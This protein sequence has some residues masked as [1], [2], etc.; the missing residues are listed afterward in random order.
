MYCIFQNS[1]PIEGM[2]NILTVLLIFIFASQLSGQKSKDLKSSFG[3]SIFNTGYS[4]D[5]SI[6]K[7]LTER[8][9]EA[10]L[11]LK[12]KERQ[13]SRL[14]SNAPLRTIPVVFHLLESTPTYTDDDVK[15]A[16]ASLNN[17][18]SH[19]NNNPNGQ[20]FSQGNIGVDTRIEFC[21]AQRAPDGGLTNG[22][23]RWTT[24]YENFDQDLED[25]KL[26][27]QGQWDPRYYLNIWIVARIDAELNA[28]YTG[29]TW[30]TRTRPA[31]YSGGP[32]GI[33][34]VDARVDGVIAA[35]MGPGLLAH[36]IGHYMSL[37][38]TF[39]ESCANGNC[40]VDG[41]QVCDTPP[42]VI[43]NSGECNRAD[44]S[45][46]TDTLSNYSN[47]N[48]P[49]D[50]PDMVTNFMDYSSCPHDFTQ[51]QAD[52]MLFT[53]DNY[54]IN[55]AVEAPS[56][57]DACIRPC[58]EDINISFDISER[59]PEPN[60]AID[61]TSTGLA[62]DT[63]E[64]YID[65]LG[66]P[67]SD[68]TITWEK[69]Y[70]PANPL[71]G[72]AA[73]LQFTFTDPGKYR[74]YL[75]AWNSATPDCYTSYSRVVRVTCG[76]IDARFFPDKRIIASKLTRA[77]LL[78]SVLFKNRSVNADSFEWIVEHEPYD[79][80]LPAQPEFRSDSTDL[81]Y[82]FTE[83]GD[84]RITLIASQGACVDT[85]GPFTL[86][87]LD[88]T[89]DASLQII[90][91]DCYK[92]DSLRVA[93]RV[94]NDGFDTIRIGM[95]VTFYDKNPLSPGPGPQI[96]KTIKLDRLV[97]GK[98]L[99]EDFVVIIPG[100][101]AKLDQLWA[102]INDPG[103]NVFPIT[104][105][106]N[107]RNVMS[108]NSV[109]PPSG[110][111]ELSYANNNTGTTSFQF[112]GV[113]SIDGPLKCTDQEVQLAASFIN[114]STLNSIS[115][116]ANNNL[117]CTNCFDPIAKLVDNQTSM[118]S[119]IFTSEYFCKDTVSITLPEAGEVVPLPTVNPV[120]ALCKGEQSLN[121]ANFANG[122]NLK[123]YPD[124]NSTNGNTSPPS[125]N[126]N[127]PG[128]YTLWLSQT[129][130]SC[131]GE[132]VPINYTINDAPD[133]PTINLQ[134]SI[135]VGGTLPDWGTWVSGNN[136]I[137][138]DNPNSGTPSNTPPNLNTTAAGNF[139]I[140]VSQSNGQ[141]ESPRVEAIYSI[142][143][144]PGAPSISGSP[145][146]CPGENATNLGSEVSGSNLL[147]YNSSNG[148]SGMDSLPMI[149]TTNPGTISFW[150]SQS[151]GQCES[152][153]ARY[154]IEILSPSPPPQVSTIPDVCQ[155][156][157]APNLASAASGN[158]LMWYENENG[159]PGSQNPP[160]INTQLT[161]SNTVWISQTT[162]TCESSRVP[163]TFSINASPD[164]PLLNA[165]IIFCRDDIPLPLESYVSGISL[166]WYEVENSNIGN[167]SA[168]IIH[169]DSAQNL[170][171]WVS[172][173]MNGCESQKQSVPISIIGIDLSAPELF[174]IPEGES[175][176]I[177][178]DFE[179]IP[180]NQAYSLTWTD[181]M[182][183][184]I[185]LDQQSILVS[186]SEDTYY[187]FR[188]EAG[189]CVEEIEIPVELIYQLKPTKV[190]SPN[191]DGR[192]DVWHVGDIER[193]P[194][195]SLRIFNR[196]GDLVYRAQPYAND[197]DGTWNN[198]KELPVATYYYVIDL[199]EEGRKPVTG[200]ITI[201]R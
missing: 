111:N 62:V 55:L 20:D 199:N 170:Q 81:N 44:N 146:L 82:V 21:L 113:L 153:R 181:A 127:I 68:Y 27:T 42:D 195:A 28:S 100:N 160:I 179:I 115:W 7:S 167:L 187:L 59:Y 162:N 31:G 16:V 101:K 60:V 140:W 109:F 174:Q 173:T 34:S 23:V 141:C 45:C 139:S 76:G 37:A 105:P 108:V 80:M 8:Q 186:P 137:W 93:F 158:N 36:E 104:W 138:H 123:W 73:N 157:I 150:V 29:R 133:G 85:C 164:P 149:N 96:L 156:A 25:A 183:Q 103:A 197:W 184:E 110:H 35:G 95:P 46:D 66:D 165:P 134:P 176:E 102:V 94:Y 88:P 154:S 69:G 10:G 86:P 48:F 130:N 49:M 90:N 51:G 64:W 201:I 120:P 106:A 143:A 145:K 4:C 1:K 32:G 24:D 12:W 18:F 194:K 131:E 6:K 117:S 47:G 54:R 175:G 147:W 148:G 87:V 191:G 13:K 75:K 192:N 5:V 125:M 200:S 97:Y 17:A 169:T 58:G 161:G 144:P 43:Q 198:G 61:F 91:I 83:P 107:D 3:Q 168:P 152:P 119:A 142:M 15:N 33:V 155:W 171:L 182:G 26:K 78:D 19:S 126:T 14:K 188:V 121:L 70:T 39:S 166:K 172:Q 129:V 92:E 193:F 74:V 116:I 2:R 52:K 38:H 84:Y 185:G 178:A 114:A 163:L 132:R 135:C 190:F 99:A 9:N 53:I 118:Q 40:L 67:G 63:Y 177:S 98:D 11:F 30:W 72:T 65:T 89:I 79:G 57:N 136:L 41:D 56:N 189:G 151:V 122:S 71:L 50:V 124:E 77:K 159:G 112:K 180:G 22:I 196:W 128:N